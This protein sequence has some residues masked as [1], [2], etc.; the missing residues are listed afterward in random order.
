MHSCKIKGF[1]IRIINN[2]IKQRMNEEIANE[3]PEITAIQGHTIGYLYENKGR[4]M[5]Q[6]NIEEELLIKR[7]TATI[8]LQSMEKKGLIIR[9][10]VKEDARLKELV[11]T[12]K[13]IKIHEQIKQVIEKIDKQ[14][15]EGF[16]EED[17]SNYLNIMEKLRENLVKHTDTKLKGEDTKNA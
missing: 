17:M 5:F 12:E 7:S 11:L 6:K 3:F 15:F 1:Y 14:T 4:K 16:S 8:M 2:L 13:A 9:K 10:S